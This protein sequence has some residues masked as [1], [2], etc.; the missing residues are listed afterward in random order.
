[1]ITLGIIKRSITGIGRFRTIYIGKKIPILGVPR[2]VNKTLVKLIKKADIFFKIILP[3]YFQ[4]S[5]ILIY[6]KKKQIVF[7]IYIIQDLL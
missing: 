6:L 5:R 2:T 4:L 1:M 7:I 3:R